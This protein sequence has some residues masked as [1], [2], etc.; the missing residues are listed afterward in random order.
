MKK[1]NLVLKLVQFCSKP[2]WINP[3][4]ENVSI[5]QHPSCVSYF[6]H[7]GYDLTPIERMYSKYNSSLPITKY[8][9]THSI[10]KQV[11]F[12]QPKQTSGAILN[13]AMILERKGYN[14]ICVDKG[15]DAFTELLK[16]SIDIVLIDLTSILYVFPP[17]RYYRTLHV[18]IL[19]LDAATHL[20]RQLMNHQ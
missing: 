16:T 20:Y 9:G 14:V 10:M 6:D 5:L 1:N 4:H 13:H 8:R 2:C 17:L 3:I 19:R 7:N 18:L 15:K 12:T 11:W